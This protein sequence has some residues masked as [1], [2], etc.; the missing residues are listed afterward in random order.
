MSAPLPPP[1]AAP[2]ASPAA[3]H[4]RGHADRLNADI[5]DPALVDLVL[6]TIDEPAYDEA[7]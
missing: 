1:D 7:L 2:P 5:W 4:S 6:G 3:R